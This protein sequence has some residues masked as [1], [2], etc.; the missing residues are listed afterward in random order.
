MLELKKVTELSGEAL[1]KILAER[2]PEQSISHKKIPDYNAH[3]D[4]I[5]SE[6]YYAWYLLYTYDALTVKGDKVLTGVVGTVYLT[7]Q[8]EIGISILNE[9]KGKGYGTEAVE[10]LMKKHPGKFL[11][12]INEKNTASIKFFKKLG[13][14]PLQITLTYE[15]GVQKKRDSD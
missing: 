13:F 11:A 10:L 7:K 12:N 15:D 1:Y 3:L 6:P 8:R 5:F 4:F 9:H 14:V 2:T